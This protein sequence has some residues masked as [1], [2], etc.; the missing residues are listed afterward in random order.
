[1]VIACLLSA[2]VGLVLENDEANTVLP[3]MVLNPLKELRVR[4]SSRVGLV[5]GVL[6][7]MS[8]HGDNDGLVWSRLNF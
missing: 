6:G 5:V 2:K 1:M 3:I 4:T 7:D 8:V